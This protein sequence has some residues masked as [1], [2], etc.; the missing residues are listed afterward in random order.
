M[1]E[2]GLEVPPS[3]KEDLEIRCLET[4]KKVKSP[5]KYF[6]FSQVPG[7][8]RTERIE[9]ILPHRELEGMPTSMV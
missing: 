5:E 3:L 8:E 4:D 6:K 9:P 7:T 2:W 1:Q